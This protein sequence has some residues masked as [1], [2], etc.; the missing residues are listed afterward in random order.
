MTN[1]EKDLF[2]AG[3]PQN[4]SQDGRQLHNNA[5]KKPDR[6]SFNEFRHTKTEANISSQNYVESLHE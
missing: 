1:N 5:I 3:L 4:M 2:L 6:I